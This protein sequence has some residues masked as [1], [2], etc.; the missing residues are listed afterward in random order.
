MRHFKITAAAAT[1][2]T[3]MTGAALAGDITVAV[4]NPSG[5][6]L[7][8]IVAAQGEGYFEQE[9]VNVNIE[10]LNGSGAVLQALAAGQAQ[11]GNP[12]AG[13]FLQARARDVPVKMIYRLNP[14]SSYS[15]VVPADSDVTDPAG[16]KGTVIGIGT[17]DGAEAAFARSIL[18]EAGLTEGED[19]SFLVVGDGGQ[20]TAGFL[21]DDIDAYA[22]ATS[23]VAILNQRGVELTPITP[24]KYKTFFG[25]SLAAS[26]E[27]LAA[28]PE[29]VEGF[30]RA[31]VRGAKW[32]ADP[33]NRE[34]LIEH[35]AAENPQEVED[36]EFANALI[37]QIIVRQ[38]PFEPEKGYG[39]QDQAAW[40]AW[41]D[42]LVA[43]GDL[44]A[45]LPDLSAVY[46]N[47]YIDAWNAE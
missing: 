20:A 8:P 4:P 13:P 23:D 11:V 22:A 45:P 10:A 7:L 33:A 17:A 1:I 9:G 47:E 28:N 39:Y 43:S 21:R 16:L 2:A 15:L 26:E 30:G 3:L 14:L 12:G 31:L 35:I 5:I 29:D 34:K 19:Y 25:N 37:D 6:L 41:Q 40:D 27:W 36:T 38:T 42:S 18:T 32:A 24:E 44:E 46:T